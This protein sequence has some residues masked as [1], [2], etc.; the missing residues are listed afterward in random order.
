MF[1]WPNTAHREANPCI[2][3]FL[4]SWAPVHNWDIVGRN[5]QTASCHLAYSSNHK[6][7]YHSAVK[8]PHLVWTWSHSWCNNRKERFP[9]LIYLYS[10][11]IASKWWLAGLYSR[12][13]E[14]RCGRR[15][16]GNNAVHIYLLWRLHLCLTSACK[17]DTSSPWSASTHSACRKDSNTAYISNKVA[18]VGRSRWRAASILRGGCGRWH[19][20]AYSWWIL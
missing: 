3:I 11:R 14:E 18:F 17:W 15:N 12:N 8:S 5:L 9:L 2:F 10:V 6:T 13:E 20:F 7:S 4:W 19:I 1:D 16:V